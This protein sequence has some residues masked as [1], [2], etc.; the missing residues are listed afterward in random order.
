MIE[1]DHEGHD[2]EGHD[3]GD[4]A[5][6]MERYEAELTDVLQALQERFAGREPSAEEVHAFLRER[7]LAEGRSAEE[8]DQFLQQLEAAEEG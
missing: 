8:A 3:H 7:L 1:A 4:D 5:L 2:H 6:D